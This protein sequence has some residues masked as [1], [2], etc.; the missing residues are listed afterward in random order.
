MLAPPTPAAHFRRSSTR[1]KPGGGIKGDRPAAALALR[2]RPAASPSLTKLRGE[3]GGNASL[4]LSAMTSSFDLGGNPSEK[5]L[6]LLRNS[7]AASFKRLL[8][9]G[10]SASESFQPLHDHAC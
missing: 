10:A 6:G 1:A 4:G 3:P 2:R 7:C 5:R 9:C 8:G